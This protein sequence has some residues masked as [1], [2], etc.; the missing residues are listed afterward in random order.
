MSQYRHAVSLNIRPAP[1]F[2]QPFTFLEYA[3]K[4][5]NKKPAEAVSLLR[6]VFLNQP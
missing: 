5:G 6:R 3:R 1:D 2:L 4:M